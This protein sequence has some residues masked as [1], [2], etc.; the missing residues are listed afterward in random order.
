MNKFQI[1]ELT[2]AFCMNFFIV[3]S[4]F[5]LSVDKFIKFLITALFIGI[6][7]F[8]VYGFWMNLKLPNSVFRLFIFAFAITITFFCT[9][10]MFYIL[11]FALSKANFSRSR[12]KVLKII[13][14][15]TFLI[16]AV[17][18]FL[19]GFSNA[20]NPKLR[21]VQIKIKRLQKPLKLAVISDIHIGKFLGVDFLQSIVDTINLTEHDAVCIVGDLFDLPP[22]NARAVCAPLLDFKKPV[23]FVLGNHEYYSGLELIDVLKEFNVRVLENENEEFMGVNL[24]GV[25]DYSGFRFKTHEPDLARAMAEKN[26]EIPTILLSHQ[27]KF[28]AQYVKDEADLCIC[29]HTHAGQIFPFGLLVQA[30]QTYL[31][32]LYDDGIKQIYVSSGAGF[33]GPAVRILAPSEIVIMELI[34]S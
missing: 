28:V 7:V 9:A 6:F 20:V 14:D 1:I 31:H 27:P 22:E 25:Y 17:A 13:L 8:E 18:C 33:W 2:I 3:R 29:G 19:K 21:N 12:R 5:L 30:D 4:F 15:L 11:N 10:V 26:P 32:G 34:P 23:F 24:S 16:F